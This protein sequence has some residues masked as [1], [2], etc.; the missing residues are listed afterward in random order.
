[1]GTWVKETDEAFYLMRGNNWISRIQKR[2]SS[3]NP[4][5]QV[6]NVEGMRQWFIRS[7]FPRAMTVSVGLEAPEPQ[8]FGGSSG[9]APPET[10]REEAA[11]V[12]APTD[13]QEDR[14]PPAGDREEHADEREGLKVKVATTTYFKLQPKLSD[15]L[16][17]AEKVLVTNGTVMDIQY[18]VDVGKNHWRIELL[19][20]T[21]GD[22]TNRSWFVF[23]PDIEV[24]TG[25]KL[26]TV[27]DTLFKAEPKMSSQLADNQKV[28][29]KNGTQ[30]T[31]LSFT[32]AAGDHLEVELADATLGED[33]K[34]NW[35]VFNPDVKVDGNRQTLEVV[36]DTIF[37]VEPVQSS[38]LP[39]T[40]KVLVK[41]GTV[42][43][44]N[45]YAQPEKN[46]VR[47]A[48]Q[49]AFLG[50]KNLTTWYAFVPD[51]QIS[52][53]EIGNRPEDSTPAAPATVSQAATPID[54]GVALTFPGFTGTYFSNNPIK[55]GLNFTWAEA[56]HVNRNNGR[57]RRPA[58]ANV[59]YNILKVAE[60]MQEIRRMYGNR[61][62]R[63]NS[64]YRDPAT[65]RA[66]GGAS[67]SRHLTGDAI[68]FV[69]PGVSNFDVYARL[70]PW[71]GSRGGLASSSAFTHIDVRG[72]RARWSYGY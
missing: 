13:H 22:K 19:N 55:T 52:G 20:A 15:Q 10:K 28:P 64:W 4:Q 45:S 43:L 62:I 44:L 67:R 32:P 7:D 27:T 48:L 25:V 68:D 72:Y 17:D 71:W 46:H 42:F 61:P 35:Y 69:I 9:S 24:L 63:I 34:R 49:G 60:V 39:D 3:T 6:L 37:K 38:Q 31:L 8:R 41:K 56:L 53:T 21:L 36:G 26:T 59:I 14:E 16:S 18:Y 12:V 5:E 1:M 23:A 66:V 2:P 33:Q 70:N 50:P 11:P 57:Y 65:N 40:D 30:H 29:V 51:I 47:V 54:R 58:N